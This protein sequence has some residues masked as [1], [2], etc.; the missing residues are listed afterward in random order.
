M[1]FWMNKQAR[2]LKS[3]IEIQV[4]RVVTKGEFFAIMALPFLAVFREGTET[5]LYLSAITAQSSGAVSAVGSVSGLGLAIGVVLLIFRGG[6]RVP[7]KPL[8][9]GSGMFLLLIA[10][11]MLAYG[12]H[13]F[14]EIG[15]IPEIYAPVWNINHIL[16]D[17]EGLGAFLKALFGYNGNPSLV[18]VLAY[19]GFLLGIGLALRRQSEISSA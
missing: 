11:G 9:Q 2:L 16:N 4:E 5:V 7:L 3:E 1:I 17:K 13:E 10:T 6:K 14:H 8:F 15:L 18:E 19:S 12:I